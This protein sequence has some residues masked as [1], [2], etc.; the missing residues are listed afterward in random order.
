MTPF[1]RILV[2]AAALARL[3]LLSGLGDRRATVLFEHLPRDGVNLRF[4]HHIALLM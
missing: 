3:R 2:I 1:L 4:R